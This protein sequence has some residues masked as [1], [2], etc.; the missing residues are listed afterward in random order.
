MAKKSESEIYYAERVKLYEDKI[1]DLLALE[2]EVANDCRQNPA[3]AGPKLFDL[4]GVMLDLA[5]NYLAV[6]GTSLAVLDSRNEN[7]LNE[8]RKSV[9]KAVIYLENVVTTKIDAPFSEYEENLAELADVSPERRYAMVRKIGLAIDLLKNAFGDNSKWR[10][11]FV[12]IEGRFAAVAKN[13]FDL[14][15]AQAATRPDAEGYVTAVRHLRLIEKLLA[16]ASEKYT[17]RYQLSTKRAQD[18]QSALFFLGALKYVYSVM[19]ERENV[20]AAQKKYDT[21]SALLRELSKKQ[22][23]VK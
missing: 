14:K 17:A 20:E 4:A 9:Y 21:G 10:W 2:T 13:L 1:R 19:G 3:T 6:N 8:A 15:N 16:D 11:A 12:E 22:A 7:A 23:E 5:S 18:I